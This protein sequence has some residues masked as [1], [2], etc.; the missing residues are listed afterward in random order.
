MLRERTLLFL[1][2]VK[3]HM[4][5]PEVKLRKPFK[6]LVITTNQPPIAIMDVSKSKGAYPKTCGQVT[7]TSIY[8]DFLL[9]CLTNVVTKTKA[10]TNIDLL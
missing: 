10:L 9:L 5:S 1:L 2:E 6:W 3:G 7:K 8:E 4:R